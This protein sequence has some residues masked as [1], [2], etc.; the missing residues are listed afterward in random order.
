MTRLVALAFVVAAPALAADAPVPVQLLGRLHFPLLH[1]PIVLLFAVA[2]LELLVR[3]RVP[4]DRQAAIDGVTRGML[5][6]AAAAAVVTAVT[7][8][9]HAQ[10]EDFGG[11]SE[12]AFLLHRAS[13]ILV[14]IVA[15]CAAVAARAR[16]RGTPS[17]LAKA[18]APMVVVGC[19]GVTFT[20]HEGGE[21]VH[22]E[23]YLTKPL[24]DP[25]STSKTSPK[26]AYL[27]KAG[28]DD[29]GPRPADDRDDGEGDARERHP[30][31]ATPEKPEYAAHIAP[32]FER[33]CV[34]CHGPE[35]RKGG[36]RLDEKR[37]AMKGGETGDTAIVPG[38]ADK[39]LVYTMASHPPDHEDVMPTKGKLLALSELE[40]IKRWIDQGASW[41]D[42]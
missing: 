25:Q 36:L 14:A 26:A 27:A 23:G 10:G 40:T 12:R 9:A 34:K 19:L 3:R 22:G 15:V 37:F 2:A 20:G 5:T 7:G 4:A 28:E 39:S 24:R 8:L 13:G 32:L 17:G 35:K 29:D 42:P 30:E 33:S 11:A 31:G 38:K 1:F 6:V 21:L 41:P 18:L 16:A